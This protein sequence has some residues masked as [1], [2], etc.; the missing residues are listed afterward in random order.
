MPAPNRRPDPARGVPWWTWAV[1]T[2]P[3]WTL[4]VAR[5]ALGV[6]YFQH[7][8]QKLVPTEFWGGFGFTR[9]MDALTGRFGIPYPVALYV[10]LAEFVCGLAL[11]FG[12]FGRLAAVLLAL[13]I[14][15][16]LWLRRGYGW[17]VDWF[18]T[19]DGRHGFEFQLLALALAILIA[20]RGSGALSIDLGLQA[21]APAPSG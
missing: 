2:Q 20:A 7:G 16:E 15:G 18:H 8:A 12:L 19:Q 4:L 3:D 10:I 13:P 5:L 9:T 21:R 17:F 14:A 6:T 1:R 11:V